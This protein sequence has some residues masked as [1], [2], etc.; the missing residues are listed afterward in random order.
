MPGD[1]ITTLVM[2]ICPPIYVISI[3]RIGEAGEQS[4]LQVIVR[5]NEAR[6]H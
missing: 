5:I 3:G 6:H 4:E 2:D 1:Y